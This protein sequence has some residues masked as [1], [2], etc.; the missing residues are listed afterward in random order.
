MP[1]LVVT[2]SER[3]VFSRAAVEQCAECDRPVSVV[4][5]DTDIDLSYRFEAFAGGRLALSGGVLGSQVVVVD[6]DVEDLNL[7]ATLLI[8][9]IKVSAASLQL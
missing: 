9:G 8:D 6:C 2:L 3:A 5:A 7:V 1:R 4:D